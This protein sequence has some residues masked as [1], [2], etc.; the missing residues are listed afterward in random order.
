M[1]SFPALLVILIK[2]S[3][4]IGKQLRLQVLFSSHLN[5]MG[6]DKFLKFLALLGAS[7]VVVIEAL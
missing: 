2:F 5:E 3:Q 7:W 1:M 6:S 4:N